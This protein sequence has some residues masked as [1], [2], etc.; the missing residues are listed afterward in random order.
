[1]KPGTLPPVTRAGE[2][3]AASAPWRTGLYAV[4]RS[5]GSNY[6]LTNDPDAALGLSSDRSVLFVDF[7]NRNTNRAP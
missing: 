5:A 7:E 1:M 6:E 2:I 3:S 4:A